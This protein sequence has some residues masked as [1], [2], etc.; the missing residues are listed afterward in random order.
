[1]CLDY[2]CPTATKRLNRDSRKQ[3]AVYKVVRYRGKCPGP[4]FF[5][6][7]NHTPRFKIGVNF[8]SD[9]GNK[10]GQYGCLIPVLRYPYGFHCFRSMKNVIDDWGVDPDCRLIR[11]Y[12]KPGDIVA[13]GTQR[14]GGRDFKCIVARKIRIYSFKDRR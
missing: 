12:V 6:G 14:M 10:H 7:H 9:P 1:M 5:G 4:E 11:V 3:I 8:A 13:A 2:V